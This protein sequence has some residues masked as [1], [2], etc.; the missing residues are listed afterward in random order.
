[1]GIRPVSG[2]AWPSR[3]TAAAMAR[4]IRHLVQPTATRSAR[5]AG[6]WRAAVKGELAGV[7]VAADEQDAVPG[8]MTGRGVAGPASIIARS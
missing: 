8:I 6:R 5:P 3:C 1:M 7:T 4:S 2:P